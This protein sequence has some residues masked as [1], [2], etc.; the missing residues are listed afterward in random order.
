MRH[1]RWPAEWEPVA[2]VL[3]AWPHAGTDWRDNLADVENTYVAL[4][5][6]IL[7][8]SSCLLLVGSAD[9][10]ARARSLLGDTALH[11]S[12]RLLT[13]DYDDT[14]LRDSGPISL[15]AND[16]DVRWL[17]FHFTGWGDKFS[18]SKDDQIVA[19]LAQ[20]AQFRHIERLRVPFALE[21]GAIESDG[22]GRLLTT[23]TCLERR[24]PGKTRQEISVVLQNTLAVNDVLGLDEGELSGDD[25]DAH[26][27]TLA[28]FAPDQTIIY[29]GCRNDADEHFPALD[30]MRTQLCALRTR[31][32]E[33]YRLIE[34]PFATAIHADD[35][36]RLAASYANF[37]ILN[38][39]VLFPVYGV[40]TDEQAL[41]V[42]QQAMPNYRIVGVP[43]RSLIE[44]NGSL[45]CVT[46]QLPEGVFA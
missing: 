44:Q 21:G 31:Q 6:A 24:H 32:G 1:W 34:L 23:W 15:V 19:F 39:A 12:L 28:R 3:L 30:A 9:V 11:P 5:Q 2:A 43:C 20:D 17:D 45:H 26:I 25:T 16:G 18:A 46:M 29:Q 22:A 36:R 27:D 35:G 40:T 8:E 41:A 38:G 7:S 4:I 37:L 14:W 42:M 13:F 10:A 33:A